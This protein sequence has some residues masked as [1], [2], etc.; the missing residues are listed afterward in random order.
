[1]APVTINWAKIDNPQYVLERFPSRRS[2]IYGTKGV[3]ACSQVRT[4]ELPL[5]EEA[6]V[7]SSK[8][9]ASVEFVKGSTFNSSDLGLGTD[10]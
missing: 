9:E 2:V 5:V 1:M 8:K 4:G 10:Y 6:I 3:V 7:A